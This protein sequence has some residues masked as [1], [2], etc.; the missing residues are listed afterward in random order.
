M[1]RQE[2]ENKLKQTSDRAKEILDKCK[3][4]NL[5]EVEIFI[6]YG[7]DTEIS[8]EK[9]D[10]NTSTF[11]EETIYGIRVIENHCQGF[12][13]TNDPDTLWDSVQQAKTLATSQ[14]SPDLALELPESST[15]SEIHGLYDE[16]IDSVDSSI[17]A[18]F[19]KEI[20]ELRESKFP[21][22]SIDNAGVSLSRSFK[23][24]L[25]TKGIDVSEIRAILNSSYMGMAIA[26]DEIG[27]F[28]Y[29]SGSGRNLETFRNNFFESYHC[30]A[31]KC[32]G[33]LGAQKIDSFK[34][35]I[36]VI[37]ETV[38]D[39]LGD[40]ISSLTG[41]MIRRQRSRFGDKINQKVASEILSISDDPLVEGLSG[42]SRFDREGMGT[43][44]KEILSNGVIRNFFYNHYEARF[45]GLKKS[46]SSA[47]GGASSTPGCGPKQIHI[48]AGNT[49]LSDMLCP[50]TK[51]ILVNRF[52]GTSDMSS[53]DFSGVVKGGFFLHNKE[54]FPVKEVTIAGNIYQILNQITAISKER[55]L[56]YNSSY[57]PHLLFEGLDITG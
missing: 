46:N 26:G 56:L 48:Q 5:K 57:V 13:T 23:S 39:F 14:N 8:I 36:I 53:G 38:F 3:K 29:D 28:D 18:D 51:T 21:Q 43:I 1:N 50:N 32:L 25:N 12:A 33:N 22:I 44:S 34:G 15:Y 10:I 49:A 35:N 11:S 47:T 24:V 45:A 52:S 16:S 20:L 27:S 17:L 7:S 54:R 9:N 19:A 37:P 6:S 41:S 30:F 42:S 40:L 4:E 31:E 2:I 55:K